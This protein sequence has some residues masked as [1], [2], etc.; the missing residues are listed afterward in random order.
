MHSVKAPVWQTQSAGPVRTAHMSVL[1]TVNIVS[2]NPAR[3]SSDN[4]PSWP[5]DNHRNSDVV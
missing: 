4:I 5:R 1:L 3:G 2:H